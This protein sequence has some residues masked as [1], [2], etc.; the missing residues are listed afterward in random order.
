[1]RVLLLGA[2][3]TRNWGGW[4]AAEFVGELCGRLQDR[5]HLNE[6]FRVYGNFEKAF[7]ERLV[8][9][10]REPENAQAQ[11]D[12]ARMQRAI[13]ETFSEMNASLAMQNVNF[14]QEGR[15]ST[16]SFLARFDAI[17]TLNQDLFFE[18]HYDG[19]ELECN[20]RWHGYVLPGV[21]VTP[22]WAA[23][24]QRRDRISLQRFVAADFALPGERIQAIYKLHGSVNWR[25]AD[26][27]ELLVI[28]TGKE[29]EIARS[30]V[31]SRYHQIFREH[32]CRGE[33]QIMVMGYSFSDAHINAVLLEG[34]RNHG[35][36]M[37]LVNPAGLSSYGAHTQQS[38]NRN[39][40]LEIPLLGICQRNLAEV[41]AS[42]DNPAFQ[43]FERFL[44]VM[45]PHLPR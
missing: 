7:G 30:P 5:P 38:Q 12:A 8:V 26:A 28:G 43:S 44:G 10:A 13:L 2:G 6:M 39:E 27:R 16:K 36:K 29:D 41:F 32:V 24:R 33:A 31:L 18:L 35:M 34:A 9:A 1:M 45:R 20:G 23:P 25:S 14:S 19:M 40:L 22:D 37:Y 3:F 21:A 17:F 11:E 15:C 4:L 42:S